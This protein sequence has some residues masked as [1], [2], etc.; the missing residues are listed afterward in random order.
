MTFL[1]VLRPLLL[2]TCWITAH[3]DPLPDTAALEAMLK[4]HV[5]PGQPASALVVGLADSSGRRV[6]AVGTRSHDDP[7]PVD[8]NAIF[9]WASITKA[10][11]GTTLS[12]LVASGSLRLDDPLSR[13]LPALADQPAGRVTLEHLATHRSGLP[14][15]PA[16]PE[17]VL[18]S[19]DPYRNTDLAR[20]VRDASG[21]EIGPLP[22]PYA[23]SNL[24]YSLLGAAL[25][26]HT[27]LPF[28]KLVQQQVLEPA[29]VTTAFVADDEAT[30]QR[31]LPGHDAQGRR[32]P[33]WHNGASAPSGGMRGDAGALL[34]LM[35]R[36]RQGLP[37]FDAPGL[38]TVRAHA[39]REHTDVG[40][41][42]HR[43][44]LAE[45]ISM[46]WHNGGSGGFR[47]FAA[48]SPEL[49]RSVV[50]LANSAGTNPDRI[51]RLLL[52]GQPV[53]P[54]QPPKAGMHTW[55]TLGL[56]SFSVGSL[57]MAWR[58]SD[59]PASRL[60]GGLQVLEAGLVPLWM[61]RVGDWQPMRAWVDI[62]PR[63]W[64]AGLLLVLTVALGRRWL[65]APAWP[66][67]KTSRV[68]L[69]LKLVVNALL[70]LAVI[71]VW[72]PA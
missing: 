19:R 15:L 58:K 18:M 70:L 24:G 55:V 22:A 11:T 66:T 7:T 72:M 52:Q 32:T 9:E 21:L 13:H 45:G 71:V 48:F 8:A 43:T 26:Q 39:G 57:A 61:M 47:S 23:Y 25:A 68:G 36:A 51:G 4:S 59:W 1:R 42:W 65:A 5:G 37:P 53:P 27:G 44:Q 60:Q 64:V 67:T 54:P 30:L 17:M 12:R 38:F 16:S 56:V 50:V 35:E 3:A 41:G 46:W 34:T 14:R 20:L 33:P 29:G 40:L 69:G 62:D 49:G 10:M 2:V 31:Q 63:P 6:V 28:G